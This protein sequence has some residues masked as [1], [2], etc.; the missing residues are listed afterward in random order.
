MNQRRRPAQGA[1]LLILS[2]GLLALVLPS[3]FAG[4]VAALQAPPLLY[5]AALLR[6]SVGVS[7]LF[8]ASI[9]R[10]RFALFFLGSVMVLGGIA[11]PIVGQGMARPILDAWQQ[12]GDVIVRGWG[13]AAFAL[14]GFLLWALAPRTE[15]PQ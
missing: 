5:L 8:A 14:G 12:G 4:L 10:A 11:T 13:L 1:A 6:F 2:L 15:V 9:S 7:L 3:R